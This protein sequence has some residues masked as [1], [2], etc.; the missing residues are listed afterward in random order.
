[1]AELFSKFNGLEMFFLVCAIIGGM[2]VFIK[3]ILQFMGGGDVGTDVDLSGDF[4][5]GHVDSDVGFRLFSLHGLSSF[6]MMFGLVGLALYRQ[7]QM[8][9]FI[10]TLGAVAAGLVSVWAIG[11]LFQGAAKLQSSGTLKT[12]DAVGST[13]IV[14]LKIP[15]GGTGQVSINFNN[16]QREF[17]AMAE[18][19]AEIP[20]GTAIRVIQVNANILVVEKLS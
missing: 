10:S 1:M 5:P 2:L 16:H 12:A 7:S 17:D 11:K 3:L 13:G 20:S 6:F 8:E 14:Y 9:V 15:P 4:D 18:G 19:G